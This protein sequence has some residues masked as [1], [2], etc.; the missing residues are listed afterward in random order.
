[1]TLAGDNRRGHRDHPT[2]GDLVQFGYPLSMAGGADNAL[3]VS[4][5][6][7]HCIRKIVENTNSKG[8]ILTVKTTT[9]LGVPGTCGSRNHAD[10]L[11][12]RFQQPGPIVLTK[13]VVPF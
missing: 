7:N 9:F 5:S 3:Y 2:R 6:S 1:M 4:D 8:Q 12:A 13:Q 10:G 11:L